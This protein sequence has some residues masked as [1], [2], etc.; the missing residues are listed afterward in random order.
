MKYQSN[1]EIKEDKEKVPK[2]LK[3]HKKR[4]K[5]KIRYQK[6]QERKKV[7]IRLRIFFNK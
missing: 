7:M 1:P 2:K 5:K 4:I 3:L 6:C